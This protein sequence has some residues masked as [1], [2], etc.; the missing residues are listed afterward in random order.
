[1]RRLGLVS[2]LCGSVVLGGA[3][4]ASVAAQ[5]PTLRVGPEVLIAP[6]TAEDVWIEPALAADPSDPDHLLAVGWRHPFGSDRAASPDERCV[7]F[8]SRDGGQSWSEHELGGISCADPWLA[9]TEGRAVLTALGRHASLPDSAD[10]L[11][12]YFSPDGGASWHDVPQSL[13]RGHDG[14]RTV[15]AADGTVYLT[16]GQSWPDAAG[17]GRFSILVARARGGIPYLAT[18]DRLVPANVNF[19]PD[20]LAVLSGGAL[21][22]TYDDYQRKV[23]GFRSRAGALEGRRAW[24]VVSDDGGRNFSIPLLINEAC[25]GRPTDLAADTSGGPFRDRLYHVCSGDDYRSILLTYSADRGD[26]WSEATPIEVEATRDGSRRE[27]QV[28]VSS[29]GVVAVAWMDRRDDDSGACYAPYVAASTDGGQTFGAPVRASA[30]LSCPDGE[31]LGFPGRRWPTGGDYFG[32]T[33]GADGRF[34]LV[35]PDARTGLFEL[36]TVTVEVSG[37]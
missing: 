23:N 26:E 5:Q 35:W 20:G 10:Q 31:R 1:M 24:A 14:P 8:L 21:V 2:A 13:G 19:N 25:Y 4:S 7:T 36:R 11:L 6:A 30:E 33:A 27:P 28:A 17:R 29:A 9:V 37:G 16:S 32:F 3:S 15:A 12:A 34:H 22:I 18:L